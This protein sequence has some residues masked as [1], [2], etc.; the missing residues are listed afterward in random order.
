MACSLKK[1]ALT[2]TLK[3]IFWLLITSGVL[4]VFVALLLFMV[5]NFATGMSFIAGGVA[6]LIP[7]AYQGISL[8]KEKHA[9]AANRIVKRF[10]RAEVAK[11]LFIGCLFILLMHWMAFNVLCFVM[12]F[13]LAQLGIWPL[14]FFR[15]YRD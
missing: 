7:S 15:V 14:V 13:L 8:F 1:E 6:S 12:G 9:T 5:L 3:Q 10:Y 2:S 11:F 4:V